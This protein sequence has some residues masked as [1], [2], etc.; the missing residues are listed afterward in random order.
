MIHT[1]IIL[2]TKNVITQNVIHF[3]YPL[4]GFLPDQNKQT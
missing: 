1:Y 4:K 2:G 3:R